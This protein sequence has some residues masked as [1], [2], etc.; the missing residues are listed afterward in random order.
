VDDK[1]K[2]RIT[3]KNVPPEVVVELS[4]RIGGTGISIYSKPRKNNR[5]DVTLSF[6]KP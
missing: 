3:S 2:Y 1:K 5:C 6:P 4:K